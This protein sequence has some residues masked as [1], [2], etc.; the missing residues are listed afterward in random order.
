MR[1][2][3]SLKHAFNFNA[4]KQ[5]GRKSPEVTEPL[6]RDWG[7]RFTV[8][9]KRASSWNGRNN[10]DFRD[11]SLP[12]GTS[13]RTL[14]RS[15]VRPETSASNRP[16]VSAM[17]MPNRDSF[18]EQSVRSGST[19][20]LEQ[21]DSFE[22]R[23]PGPTRPSTSFYDQKA[24]TP[25]ASA[26]SLPRS[27]HVRQFTPT[28]SSTVLPAQNL[29]GTSRASNPFGAQS[30]AHYAHPLP[31]P[32]TNSQTV[33]PEKLS[34]FSWTNSQAP[35]TPREPRCSIATSEASVA[36]YRT[37]ESWVGQQTYAVQERQIRELLQ[38]SS[39]PARGADGQERKRTSPPPDLQTQEEMLETDPFPQT[40]LPKQYRH[41]KKLSDAS[42]FRHHPGE[43]VR[44][45]SGRRVPSAI[46]DRAVG[47]R[48]NML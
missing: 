35:Q 23:M 22:K 36:R 14:G 6:G 45:P 40:E 39:T 8:W 27:P 42:V 28:P 15:L 5:R 17:Q 24:V 1:K 48:V 20:T 44:V 26:L 38:T 2:G 16:L 9:N 30:S 47:Q 25:P 31:L 33:H 12:N 3:Y 29:Y 7:R 43:I 19:R 11:D 32:R 46:L 13:P 21:P 34:R 41:Q 10:W 4:E 18:R 37:V